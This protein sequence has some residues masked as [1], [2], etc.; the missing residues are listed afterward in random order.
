M[1][2]FLLVMGFFGITGKYWDMNV[3]V[4]LFPVIVLLMALFGLGM[5][6]IFSALTTR[7]RD[8]YF[9]LTFAIQLA[10]YSTTVVY[11]LSKAPEKYRWI[12]DLNPL[13]PLIETFR[14]GFLGKASFDWMSL[15]ISAISIVLLTVIGAVMFNKAERT[16]I[17]TV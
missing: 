16:F 3:Y 11:P 10:M 13:T 12:I 6:M 5:G 17:D 2:L 9:L 7:Y 4:F 15:S 14:Y 1:G 8:L